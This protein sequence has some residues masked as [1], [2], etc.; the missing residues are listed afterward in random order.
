MNTVNT[1][2]MASGNSFTPD[3]ETSRML[4][5]QLPHLCDEE[6]EC[7]ISDYNNLN[8]RSTVCCECR[9]PL[10]DDEVEY[11]KE[12]PGDYF[13]PPHWVQACPYCGKDTC[14]E[15]ETIAEF[16]RRYYA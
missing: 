5:V 12:C 3:T 2:V 13:T 14:L 8:L 4:S 11:R 15:D 9:E 1:Q 16:D 6:I 10:S 7:V